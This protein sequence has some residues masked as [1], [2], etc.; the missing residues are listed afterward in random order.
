MPC[1]V[2]YSMPLRW[3][4]GVG[5]GGG[6]GLR[7]GKRW[8]EIDQHLVLKENLL[9][10]ASQAQILEIR[11]ALVTPLAMCEN[12]LQFT[13]L[14]RKQER[15]STIAVQLLWAA[16]CSIRQ[17]KRVKRTYTDTLPRTVA[18]NIPFCKNQVVSRCRADPQYTPRG[19]QGQDQDEATCALGKEAKRPPDG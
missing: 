3:N 9:G 17:V 14:R 7:K 13:L 18:K 15:K 16:M 1:P 8:G 11:Y 4:I 5:W 12:Y 2:G 10:C 19:D 6:W